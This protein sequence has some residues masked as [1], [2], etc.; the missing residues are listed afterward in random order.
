VYAQNTLNWNKLS[1]TTGIRGEFIDSSYQNRKPGTEQDWLEKSTHIW[2]PSISTFY[3]MSS[4]LGFLFGIHEGH[5]PT[6][7]K[8]TPGVQ[9]EKS[10]NYELGMRFANNGTKADLIGFFND[11]DNL[12]ESCTFSASAECIESIDQE[13]N[14][15]EVDIFGI[16]ATLGHSFS[17]TNSIDMPISLVY[18]Y[19]ESEFKTELES[20]F[21]LWGNVQPG[22]SVPYLPDHQLTFTVG[23]ANDYWQVSL[24]ARYVG[25]MVETAGTGVDLAGV[26]TKAHTV[27]D[28]SA[29]YDFEDMGSIY[30]KLDNVFD[31][32]EVVS[33]RPYGARP[34][35]PRQLVAGYKYRF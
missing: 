19:T 32:V 29:G 6:S 3:Q 18:T 28:L 9:A 8:Q 33:H 25:E 23:L 13:Y 35:K 7:P 14:G 24:L 15:G 20:T 4:S 1:V 11:Y 30:V 31:S 10:L 16:E 21:P 27:V 26:S 5:V 34:S 22:D 17:L 2:L 12:K